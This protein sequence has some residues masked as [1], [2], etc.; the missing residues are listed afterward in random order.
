MND[1]SPQPTSNFN[2]RAFAIPLAVFSIVALWGNE[3]GEF[4]EEQ[5]GWL[6]L[7]GFLASLAMAFKFR[8][9]MHAMTPEDPVKTMVAIGERIAALRYEYKKAASVGS[10][11]DDEQLHVFA[12]PWDT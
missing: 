4:D 2:G 3:R 9:D 12:P 8:G 11:N 7:I 10:G 5:F 1:T 6:L